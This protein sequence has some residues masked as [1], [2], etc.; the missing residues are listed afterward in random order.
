M[1]AI[2]GLGQIAIWESG[3]LWLFR[4]ASDQA[5]TA[6][7]SHHSIQIAF[8]LQGEFTFDAGDETA[9]GPITAVRQDTPHI[10]RASGAVAHLFVEPE[11]PA[12]RALASQLFGRSALASLDTA[13]AKAALQ[14]LRE[15]FG[16]GAGTDQL[17]A[18][19][20]RIVADL[21]AVASAPPVDRRVLAMIDHAANGLDGP[22]TLTSA[23]AAACLS[24]S[25]ARHLFV[26]QTG[27][28][29]SAY[30]LWLRLERAVE[31]YAAGQSL[32]VAAHEAGFADSAHFS[33]TFKRTFGLPAAT[34]RIHQ[35]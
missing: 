2:V 26:E 4:A 15:C 13:L 18:L 30:V 25:R 27:I 35:A 31:G 9:R 34:L 12:G 10:F 17:K 24:P 21:A 19:G 22:P 14:D 29:F 16:Q 20:A 1:A 33:R 6:V 11:S 23:A 28:P 7:H 8:S 32:T 3:S 5:E